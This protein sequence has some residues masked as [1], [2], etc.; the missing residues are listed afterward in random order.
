MEYRFRSD[1][2]Y[3]YVDA[4]PVF[5]DVREDRY[6]MLQDVLEAAFKAF[7]AGDE[8][9]PDLLGRLSHAEI[10]EPGDGIDGVPSPP[11]IISPQQST[12]ENTQVHRRS[13]ALATMK[14]MT[15]LCRSGPRLRRNGFARSI[16]QLRQRKGD[17]AGRGPF[18]QAVVESRAADFQ[19]ARCLFPAPQN[20]LPDSL[21]LLDFLFGD[22]IIADLVI[23]VR[24]NPYGAHCWVQSKDILLNETI[25]YAESF[26]PILVV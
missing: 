17:L 23:G 24:M 22:G 16:A 10:L 13:G 25:D 7:I 19:A 2:A 1:L 6:F 12:L 26:T 9:S 20:C 21:A 3:C 4:R 11:A 14:A 5:L 15:C 8:V 18:C